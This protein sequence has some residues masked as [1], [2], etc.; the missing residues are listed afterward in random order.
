M[1]SGISFLAV[2]CVSCACY[3]QPVAACAI[4]RGNIRLTCPSGWTVLEESDHE[5][6]IA[7][8]T[9]P[10]DA[11]KNV[12]GG[13]GKAW[14]NISTLPRQY[15]DLGEWIF[16]GTKVAPESV[17]TTTSIRNPTTGDV[18]VTCMESREKSGTLYYSCFFQLGK[19]PTL[20]ELNYR[21]E[22]PKQVDYRSSV[23]KMIEGGKASK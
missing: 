6:T 2:F 14:M 3:G 23:L 9:R 13:P 7:N 11:P 10:A 8:Y 22:D 18:K 1:K 4:S 20:I 17:R 19:T 15:R 5:S 12:F 21:A 16:A